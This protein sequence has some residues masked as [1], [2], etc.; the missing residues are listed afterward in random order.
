MVGCGLLKKAVS[1]ELLIPLE[2]AEK[3]PDPP[4]V[5]ISSFL[6]SE[7]LQSLAVFRQGELPYDAI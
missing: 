3:I 7:A 2:Q 6:R 4:S 1:N 5:S